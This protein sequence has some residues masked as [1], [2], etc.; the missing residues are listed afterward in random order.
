MGNGSY[1]TLSPRQQLTATPC[2]L[3]AVTAG[4]LT[5]NGCVSGT[6][7]AAGSV[8]NQQVASGI[9]YSKLSGAPT[10]LPPKIRE[11][12]CARAS[13][14]KRFRA[15]VSV[16]LRL[17]LALLWASAT[18]AL[19]VAQGGGG[20]D[21]SDNVIA[22]G[23]ATFST[24]G[25]FILGGT[26]GQSDAGTLSGATYVDAGG[27]WTKLSRAA[28]AQTPSATNSATLS[29][30]GTPSVTPTNAPPSA[31]QT[32]ESGRTS[33]PT[34]TSTNS[35]ATAPPS[36][37]PSPTLT[38]TPTKAFTPTPAPTPAGSSTTTATSTKTPSAPTQTPSS[39]PMLITATPTPTTT[40]TPTAS[41]TALSTPTP[42]P[43]SM[44]CI[45]DCG[46]THAVAVNDLIT[47]VNIALGETA[48]TVCLHGVPG[49][50]DADVALIIR[51]VNNALNGCS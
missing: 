30:A 35:P 27:F 15:L 40:G 2:A 17:S 48:P 51:A 23:G 44:P 7:L 24:G 33:T 45:G 21:L 22:G 9:A 38:M 32:V 10:A 39:T 13:R 19:A 4:G 25:G 14:M 47:Q 3:Y 8:T 1:T 26:I 43:T 50:A 34:V 18:G 49:G 29:P 36:I 16:S 11:V 37:P 20:Y 28:A 31:T 46:G 42:T 41:V 5:C 12:R 6:N